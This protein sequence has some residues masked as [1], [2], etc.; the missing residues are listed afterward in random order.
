MDMLQ[1]FQLRITLSREAWLES[2]NT[3]ILRKEKL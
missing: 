2:E 1:K 3:D